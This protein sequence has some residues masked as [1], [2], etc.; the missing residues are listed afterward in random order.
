MAHARQDY[1][2]SSESLD[3]LGIESLGLKNPDRR[4]RASAQ[5]ESNGFSMPDYFGVYLRTSGSRDG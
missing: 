1:F 3:F 5:F 2:P 4:K